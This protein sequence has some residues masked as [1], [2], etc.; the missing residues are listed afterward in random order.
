M[1]RGIPV[2]MYM[3][4]VIWNVL[5]AKRR[6]VQHG[7]VIYS[8]RTGSNQI[9]LTH[10]LRRVTYGPPPASPPSSVS[11]DTRLTGNG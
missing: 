5:N 11:S 7:H 6:L 1:R 10:L 9:R 2:F 3:K 8:N 4:T